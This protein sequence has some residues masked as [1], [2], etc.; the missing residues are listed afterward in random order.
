MC[1]HHSVFRPTFPIPDMSVSELE[2]AATAPSRWIALSSSK[3]RN[4]DE[5]LPSRR[6]RATRII[7][8]PTP[9]TEINSQDLEDLKWKIQDLKNVYLVPGGRYLVAA[10]RYVMA[11]GY[12]YSYKCLVGVWDLGYVSEGDM[13][14][15][16]KSTRVWTTRVDKIDRFIV[17][18][19]PDGL[20]IRILT[21]SYVNNL[22]QDI[23]YCPLLTH[24]LGLITFCVSSRSIPNRRPTSMQKLGSSL[25]TS[26]S[27]WNSVF[28]EIEP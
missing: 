26:L 21:C 18:P 14:S 22:F 19:T 4:T 2:R 15:D 11:A 17:N 5:I 28:V 7:N 13:S 20:G 25:S 3:D 9:L 8:K 27:T 10:G 23:F 6:S 1:Y 16:G 24:F 12:G